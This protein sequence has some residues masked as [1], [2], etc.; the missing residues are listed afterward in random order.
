MSKSDLTAQ[1]VRELF[2]YD[3]DAGVLIR[4]TKTL[5]SPIGA[6]AGNGKNCQRGI[7]WVDGYLFKTHR[8]AWL[9]SMGLGLKAKLTILMG[10]NPI[11]G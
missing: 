5:K 6:E 10:A 3:H 4:R 2:Q 8:I 1:R 9:H 11:T 7:I